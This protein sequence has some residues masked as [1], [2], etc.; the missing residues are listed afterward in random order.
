MVFTARTFTL[1]IGRD[2]REAVRAKSILLM[3]IIRTRFVGASVMLQRR[4]TLAADGFRRLFASALA[5]GFTTSGIGTLNMV[6]SIDHKDIKYITPA[7]ITGCDKSIRLVV[8]ILVRHF[9][10][11]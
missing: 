9:S 8:S 6:M 4:T 1:F 10:W 11:L 5:T 2:S 7:H 3:V